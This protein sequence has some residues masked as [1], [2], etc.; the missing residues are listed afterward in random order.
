MA[1]ISKFYKTL[2]SR[3]KQVDRNYGLRQQVLKMITLRL[4]DEQNSEL[5]K[6]PKEEE[7]WAVV[8]NL[9]KNKAPGL[10]G[11]TAEVLRACW[12]MVHTTFVQSIHK[13]W[14]DACLPARVLRRVQECFV[15]CSNLFLN[16]K[17]LLN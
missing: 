11:V 14:I 5:V 12:G 3:N 9:P 13:F 10:D 17:T 16:W 6:L 15:E 2:Y 8:D 7:I 1:E 4:N